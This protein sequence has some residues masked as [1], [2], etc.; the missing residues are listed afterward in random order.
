MQW[1]WTP[2][3]LPLIISAFIILFN[4]IYTFS[5]GR[6][7]ITVYFGFYLLGLFLWLAFYGLQISADTLELKTVFLNLKYFGAA[8]IP[9]TWFLF[10]AYFTSRKRFSTKWVT[11]LLFLI[12]TIVIL[13]IWTNPLH[14]RFFS[15]IGLINVDGHILIDLQHGFLFWIYYIYSGIIVI[16]SLFI[17]LSRY[18]SSNRINR[19]QIL[20]I[21]II[22]IFVMLVNFVDVTLHEFIPYIDITPL[23]FG[24]TGIIL[25]IILFRFKLLDIIPLAQEYAL[26]NMKDMI[27]IVNTKSEI[28]YIN[29]STEEF[30]KTTKWQIGIPAQSLFK[31]RPLFRDYLIKN[32]TEYETSVYC[33]KTNRYFDLSCTTINKYNRVLGRLYIVRDVTEQK[34]ALQTMERYQFMVNT[35]PDLMALINRDLHYEE[36]SNSFCEWFDLNREDIIGHPVREIWGEKTFNDYISPFVRYCFLDNRTKFE[37][38]YRFANKGHRQLDI[39]HIPFRDENGS[40]THSVMI[41]H[42]MTDYYQ[43]KLELEETLQ[44][45]KKTNTDL[46]QAL[47][48][49]KKMQEQIITQEK[50]ASLGTLTAGIAHE[51]KNPLN[52]VK[53]FS[54]VTLD[55]VEDILSNLAKIESKTELIEMIEDDVNMV[56]ENTLKIIEHG[57]RANNII[58]SMLLHSR[59]SSGHYIETN[60]NSVLDEYLMLSFHGFRSRYPGF[61]TSIIKEYDPEIGIVLL[62]G[63][64]LSRVFVNLIDNAFYSMNQKLLEKGNDYKP[65]IRVT[66]RNLGNNLEIHI[67]DNGTGIPKGIRDRIFHPFFTTKPSGDGTGLGLSITYDIIVVKHGGKIEVNSEDGE[68]TE[69][70]ITLPK[71][72]KK[73]R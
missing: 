31:Q 57:N 46:N 15:Y 66:T 22:N 4:I 32:D 45:L 20:L 11:A 44:Q 26:E 39:M 69:F 14:N 1:Q 67:R 6:D 17:I 62:L 47:D 51:I 9:T 7:K 8:T 12:P 16:S 64:E 18:Q 48:N 36:V 40:V 73:H 56:K 21:L 34:F 58:Q 27:I 61:N 37:L 49:V 42:D 68:F 30:L 19:I 35:S 54:D 71:Q 24:I 25:T 28:L 52:F 23:T 10:S 59:N 70:M 3:L 38:K 65:E 13:F 63:Q 72:M 5:R 41:A 55:N 53:N 43:V 50:L 29:P 60:L 2:Y 33:D